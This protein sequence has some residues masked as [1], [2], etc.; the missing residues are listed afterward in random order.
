[1]K[2]TKPK[3][4]RK[5]LFWR[6]NKFTNLWDPY[7]RVSIKIGDK[8]KRQETKLHWQGDE[9][10]LDELFWKCESGL[11]PKFQPRLPKT[12]WGNLYLAWKSDPK[13]AKSLAPS[14]LTSYRRSIERLM[15]KNV[16]KDVKQTT[17]QALRAIH[18]SM[19]DTPRQAD[20][21]ITTISMLWNYAKREL[22]WDIGENPAT[23]FKRYGTTN[24]F[25]AWPEWM[26]E[27]LEEAPPPVR[28]ACKLILNTGQRPGA[29]IN[30][31][32]D[33]FRFPD[34]VL[35]DEKTKCEY[36]VTCP[37]PLCDLYREIDRE[38]DYL[39]AKNLREPLGYDVVQKQ[40]SA[41]RKTL[42]P[43]ASKYSFHGLR[44]LAIIRLAEAG[45]SDAEIQSITNQ[46]L[47]T[48]A[49]YRKG[50][51]RKKLSANAFARGV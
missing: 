16:D 10:L 38:G 14:T 49:Y 29:A 30:M 44:K 41:W 6:Y 50:A 13:V 51:N 42:G 7:H 33:Q 18:L 35:R 9:R 3:L 27:K 8:V 21:L 24:P 43:E 23:Q 46:T 48:V 31:R 45:C 5:H 25:E 4:R 19:V 39:I 12:T 2:P 34:V 20:K 15:V 26:V 37:R 36:E 22:D 1:M 40:F 28:L 17:R 11:H 47:E 32:H